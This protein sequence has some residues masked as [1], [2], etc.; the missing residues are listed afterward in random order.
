MAAAN[1]LAQHSGFCPSCS[2]RK[3]FT[4]ILIK[5]DDGISG[6]IGPAIVMTVTGHW[7]K[8]RPDLNGKGGSHG[9]I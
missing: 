4:Q 3:L 5:A 9:I 1:D 8:F 6:I 2:G 7:Q